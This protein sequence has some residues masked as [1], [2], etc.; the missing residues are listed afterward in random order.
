MQFRR[1]GDWH[2]PGLLRQQPGERDLCGRCLFS[3]GNL[4]KQIDEG[5]VCF[6]SLWRKAWDDVAEVLTV[7]RSV[8]I[9]L[10]AEEASTKWAE[11]NESDSE[12]FAG[13]Q[14]FLL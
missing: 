4:R 9:D 1:A 10:S 7:E 6:P 5:L 12:L 14:H 8:L 3:F 11:G 13:R 2:N